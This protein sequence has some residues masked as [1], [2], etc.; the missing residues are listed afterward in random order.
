MKVIRVV[1]LVAVSLMLR[2]S[3]YAQ[4][5]TGS[6]AGIVT[7]PSSAVLPGTTVTLSGEKLIGGA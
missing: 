3:A 1:A 2:T 7:D 6:I 5:E 4:V